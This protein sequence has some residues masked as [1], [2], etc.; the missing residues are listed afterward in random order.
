M[1]R[2]M[3]SAMSPRPR[4]VSVAPLIA[5]R[6]PY[7]FARRQSP[8]AGEGALPPRGPGSAVRVLARVIGLELARLQ[9]PPP[10][11][12]GPVPR[13]RRLE[14]GIEGMPR[15]PAE[16]ADPGRIERVAPVV[17]RP[18]P[19]RL[20]QRLGL[21][22]EPEDPARQVGVLDLGAAPDV[23]D[24]TVAAP[25]Q[26]QIDRLA[27]VEHVEPVPDVLAVAVEGERP[28]LDRI[29]DE[30]WGQRLRILVRAEVVRGAGDDDRQP[31]GRPVRARQQVAGGFR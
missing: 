18:V 10:R 2:W 15:R 16:V 6:V 13:H 1:Y 8:P 24:L 22:E 30:E 14:R 12:V 5:G 7:F 27:V 28:V 23:V 19:H 9:R 26:D 21:A 25:V 17:P 20:D 31:V 29:R 4:Y 3:G 11:L